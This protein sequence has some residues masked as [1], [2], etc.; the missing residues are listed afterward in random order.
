VKA[1][2]PNANVISGLVRK[3]AR[4]LGRLRVADTAT[5][6]DAIW[7]EMAH[8]EAVIRMFDPSKIRGTFGPFDIAVLVDPDTLGTPS[9]SC[10]RWANP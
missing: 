6:A 1:R 10:A 2:R 7:T 9:R 8:T 3:Y 5:E 4:M